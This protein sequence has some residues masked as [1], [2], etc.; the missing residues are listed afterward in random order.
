MLVFLSHDNFLDAPKCLL[1]QNEVLKIVPE[2]IQSICIFEV[3]FYGGFSLNTG[4][5][6]FTDLSCKVYFITLKK[7]PFFPIEDGVKLMYIGLVLHID[8]G[9]S[10]VALTLALLSYLKVHG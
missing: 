6:N 2:T 9:I 4:I 1:R 7:L 10:I 3:F 8:E 5:S